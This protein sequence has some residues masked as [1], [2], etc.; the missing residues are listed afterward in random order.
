MFTAFISFLNCV[1][2]QH[3]LQVLQ[4]C[5]CDGSL[6]EM[7]EQPRTILS[8]EQKLKIERNRQEAIRKLKQ[9]MASGSGECES[10]CDAVKA[11][12]RGHCE[13]AQSVEIMSWTCDNLLEDGTVCGGSFD[14][15]TQLHFGELVCYQCKCKTDYEYLSKD[16]LKKEY[17]LSEACIRKMRFTEKPNALNPRWAPIKLFMRKDA[18]AEATSKWGSMDAL[19][20]ER[21]KRELKKYESS[22]KR[23]Q[24]LFVG[25]ND[26]IGSISSNRAGRKRKLHDD[27]DTMVA[28]VR[29]EG[30]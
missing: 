11:S 5:L 18:I 3:C 30:R 19:A 23:T 20:A 4:H 10:S 13:G 27:L 8:E 9:H 26:D 15:R 14:K 25:P 22:V 1:Q 7:D 29:G 24:H 17:M 6:A 16:A 2:A 12:T 28:I 21:R